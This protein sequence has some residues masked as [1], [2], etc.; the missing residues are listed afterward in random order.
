VTAGTQRPVARVGLATCATVPVGDPDDALLTD[1]LADR[2]V[3]STWVTWTESEPST[4]HEQID[5]LVLRSTWD[6]TDDRSA[7]VA[8]LKAASVPVFNPP[9]IVEWNSSKAYMLDLEAAG[10]PVVPTRIV[11]SDAEELL[12]PEYVDEFVVKPAI[13]AGSRGAD[14]FL[15]NDDGI[16][17]ARRHAAQLIESGTPAVVQ[18]YLPSVDAG[19]ETA[20]LYFDGVYSHAAA[21]GP[22]L[23]RD[24]GQEAR[25]MFEGLYFVEK[26]TRRL[27]SP[28]Q[29]AV[30]ERALAAV[31]G[32][33]PLYARVD[34]VDAPDG[35]PVVLELELIE[36]SLFLAFDDGAADRAAAAIAARVRSI[37]PRDAD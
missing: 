3:E 27:A 37:D 20:L 2:G 34:L 35:S 6:Y 24:G 22:M 10:V 4:L 17:R 25:K 12:A 31:H 18:P 11:A 28:E 33:A 26:M 23:A 32:E 16:A 1:R 13:G 7:F 15:A 8:W 19:S 14:R 36:P 30:A 29:R 21:K 9:G 5:A